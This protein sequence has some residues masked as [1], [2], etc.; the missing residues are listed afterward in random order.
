MEVTVPFRQAPA[1][2]S[3]LGSNLRP[4]LFIFRQVLLAGILLVTFGALYFKMVVQGPAHTRQVALKIILD[5]RGMRNFSSLASRGQ[6]MLGK[7]G[8]S[9]GVSGPVVGWN[10]A[11]ALQAKFLMLIKPFQLIPDFLWLQHFWFCLAFLSLP[12]SQCHALKN[13]KLSFF[14]CFGV[15]NTFAFSLIVPL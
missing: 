8:C 5:D 11:G 15:N 3:G 4:Q 2:F 1:C 14:V 6:V 7:Q 10:R 12:T 9:P 13:T